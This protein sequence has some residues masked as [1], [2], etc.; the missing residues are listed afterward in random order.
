MQET[1]T[2]SGR[3]TDDTGEPIP[4]ANVLIEGTTIGAAGNITGS[5]VISRVPPG[6]HNVRAS[7]VGFRSQTHAVTVRPGE[8]VTQN[9]TLATDILRMDAIV[10]S[11]TPGGVGVRKRDAS[12][13]ITTVEASD[14][15]Q[16]SPA[17]TANLMELVPGVWSESSGG[18]AGANIDVRGL[19]GG[20]D[21]PFVT[22]SINGAPL[23]GTEMLSFFE[24]ST[25]FRV[26]ETVASAEALRGGPNSVFSSGEPGVTMNFNLLRGTDETRARVKYSTS[27]YNLQRVDAVVSGKL[28]DGLYYM[29]GGYAQTSPG[30]RK[31][32]FNAEKGQQFTTQLTRI[33]DRGVINAFTRIT[34]DHGQWILPMSLDTDNKLGTFAQL[35]NATRF[36]ELQIN[37]QG[38]SAIFDFSKGRGWAGSVSGLNATFDLGTGWTVRDNLSYTKGEANTFG[39]VPD[40]SP[41]RVSSLGVSSVATRGG[42]T[43]SGS[44]WIQNY[45]HWVV[46]KDIESFTNDVSLAKVWGEHDITIGFY[47][48]WWSAKDFWTLGNFTPVHNV[49]NGDFLEAGIGCDS[50]ANNGSNSGCWSYGIRSAGDARVFAFY[51]AESWKVTPV[52]R[53]DLGVRYEKIDLEYI[54]DAGPGYPDGVRDMAISLDDNKWA[55]TGAVNYD[56]TEDLGVFGRFSDGFVFPHFDNLREND[57]S[58]NKVRQ[59]EAGVKYAPRKLFSLFG[60]GY[61]T[62]YDAFES[63]VG[64]GFTPRRFKTESYGVELDGALFIGDLTVRAIGTIQ[65]TKIKESDNPALVGNSVLRQPDL[66][67]RLAP[68][69]SFPAGDFNANVYAALRLVGKRW[70]DNDNVVELDGYSKIDAGATVSTKTG[71]SFNIHIDNLTDSDALTEGDPRVLGARNGRPIF[72]RS[73]KFSVGYDL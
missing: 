66:Q 60:T 18:V 57:Q 54:L 19:P 30:V 34:D 4:L 13:A 67:I 37:A 32:E 70:A 49:R 72:G 33:F 5:Y 11:G 23:Y 27:D 71:L 1:G 20:G 28:T 59:Y 22:M 51:A 58:T 15:V 26:D 10:V 42:Q 6:T 16:F 52:L 9:F 61:F 8:T 48:A 44:A 40:G 2:I 46:M 69:Y 55:F 65:K 39:F 43:L 36:R 24:Q 41:I 35:G 14:I 3:V 7:A 17:S 62:N 31:A 29:A 56:V 63:L 21:A 64:G 12:F 38:D 73:M 68:N 47:Q 50:L 25:I 53:I 45:G